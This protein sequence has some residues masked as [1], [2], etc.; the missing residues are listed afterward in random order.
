MFFLALFKL[1][2]YMYRYRIW[3]NQDKDPINHMLVCRV[4]TMLIINII[5][6]IQ[7][8]IAIII[9]NLTPKIRLRLFEQLKEADLGYLYFAFY[10][11]AI[12]FYVHAIL[13]LIYNFFYFLFLAM[14]YL[15]LNYYGSFSNDDEEDD[16][17]ISIV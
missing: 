12:V 16:Q 10:N 17:D 13:F 11:V 1:I 5:E 15:Y 3:N 9:K 7:F 2:F 6:A 4:K 14:I 8:T